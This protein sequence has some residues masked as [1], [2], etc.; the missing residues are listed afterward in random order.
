MRI[1]YVCKDC[2]KEWGDEVFPTGSLVESLCP[3]CENWRTGRGP[4]PFRNEVEI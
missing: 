4:N 2:A 1:R 3:E